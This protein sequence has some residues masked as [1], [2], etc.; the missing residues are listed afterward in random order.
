MKKTTLSLNDEITAEMLDD[1]SKENIERI[2]SN[3]EEMQELEAR[4]NEDN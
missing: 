1:D 4:H 2:I 3:I